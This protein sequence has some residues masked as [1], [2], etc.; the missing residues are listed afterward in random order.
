MNQLYLI[1]IELSY[2][3]CCIV[4]KVL[5]AVVLSSRI[6][7]WAQASKHSRVEIGLAG[8]MVATKAPA[9]FFLIKHVIIPFH[10]LQLLAHNV[11]LN[12]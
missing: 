3:D 11:L 7:Q 4:H 10:V 5:K 8:T 2:L 9:L 1:G 12:L 6:K